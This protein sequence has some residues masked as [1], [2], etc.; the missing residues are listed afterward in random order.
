M[1]DPRPG[2]PK[3]YDA[4]SVSDH[5]NKMDLLLKGMAERG[6]RVNDVDVADLQ[7]QIDVT[8]VKTDR[9]SAA[10]WDVATDYHRRATRALPLG[11]LIGL[12]AGYWL[13]VALHASCT[14]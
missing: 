6:G 5:L 2:W 13:A 11:I 7:T 8:K 3:M 4:W 14:T 10:L 12:V 9:A 1:R